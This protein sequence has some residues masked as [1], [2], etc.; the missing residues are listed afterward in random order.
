MLEPTLRCGLQ[1]GSLDIVVCPAGELVMR[2][3][4]SRQVW[5]VQLM[6]PSRAL[7]ALEVWTRERRECK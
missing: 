6:L 3:K 2:H 7:S 4:H 1:V 5:E